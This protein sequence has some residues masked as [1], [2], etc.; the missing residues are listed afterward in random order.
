[1]GYRKM[2]MATVCPK[3]FS[4]NKKYKGKRGQ[5]QCLKNKDSRDSKKELQ[6]IA[7]AAD[8]SIYKRRKDDMGFTKTPLSMKALRARLTRMKV[9]H[10]FGMSTVCPPGKVPNRNWKPGRGKRQCLRE[11]KKELSLKQLQRIAKA[12]DV[13]IYKRRKDDM[14][15]TK[16]P[17]SIKSLKSRLTRMKVSY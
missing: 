12:A 1:M 16:T 11:K 8:V 4:A 2:Y 7:K 10:N 9:S 13:S 17:L 3:G 14:G 15:F 6:R 5:R